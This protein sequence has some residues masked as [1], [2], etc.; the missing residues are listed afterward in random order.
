MRMDWYQDGLDLSS[1]VRHHQH[2]LQCFLFPKIL[3]SVSMLHPAA[4]T[5]ILFSS[6]C[7]EMELIQCKI[8]LLSHPLLFSFSFFILDQLLDL[9]HHMDPQAVESA[10]LRLACCN[11]MAEMN[12]KRRWEQGEEG[13]DLSMT[14]KISTAAG[15][16]ASWKH[17]LG[18]STGLLVR[19][20]KLTSSLWHPYILVLPSAKWE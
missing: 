14:S 16:F 13:P 10:Q 6:Q 12:T 15:C 9:I 11:T 17:G 2:Q 7:L 8:A 5:G 1:V 3:T 19:T 20:F 4:F 18:L